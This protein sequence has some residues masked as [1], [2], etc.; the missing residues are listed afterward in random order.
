MIL[1]SAQRGSRGERVIAIVHVLRQRVLAA[2]VRDV[3]ILIT[4]HDR[5]H[6]LALQAEQQ[7]ADGIRIAW[8]FGTAATRSVRPKPTVEYSG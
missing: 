5:M 2:V 3:Q 1:R 6:P 7:V 8:I 4:S